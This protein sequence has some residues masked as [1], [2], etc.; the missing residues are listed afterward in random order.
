MSQR[1]IY[2]IQYSDF[3]TK[4]RNATNL[5]KK[6]EKPNKEA[7][8]NYVRKH[9]VPEPVMWSRGK[10]GTLSGKVNAVIIDGVG[11]ADGY[12]IYSS[13]EAFCLKFESG[14]E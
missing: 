4:L 13:D 12:Y 11:E 6:I 2:E 8:N 9:N 1:R 10:S 5:H 3:S 14:L 7:W